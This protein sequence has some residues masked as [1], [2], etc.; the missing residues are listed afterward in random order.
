MIGSLTAG[1]ILALYTWFPLAAL[2]IIMLLIAR[3]YERF[4]GVRT[5]FQGFLIPL[6]LSGVGM[7]RYASLNDI[8]GDPLA[9]LALVGAGL[10][11][12]ILCI[13]IYRRMLRP[14]PDE[15]TDE[16]LD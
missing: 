11:L 4:S 7:V 15:N 10:T 8:V 16:P 2:L 9:D 12:M 13:H 14:Q 1:Q 3:F 6:V 5:Y